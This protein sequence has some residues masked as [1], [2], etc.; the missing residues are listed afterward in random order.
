METNYMNEGYKIINNLGE[1]EVI[2]I[3]YNINNVE[4]YRFQQNHLDEA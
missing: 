1:E 4:C 2:Q 3:P